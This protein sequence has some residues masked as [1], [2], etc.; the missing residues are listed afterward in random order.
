MVKIPLFVEEK[1]FVKTLNIYLK[2][3]LLDCYAVTFVQ[4]HEIT[5]TS[6]YR[7]KFYKFYNKLKA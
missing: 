7:N 2:K 5:M 1:S 3:D 4:L 6:N